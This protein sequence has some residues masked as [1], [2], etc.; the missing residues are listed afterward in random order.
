MFQNAEVAAE[1]GAAVARRHQLVAGRN[2]QL[3]REVRKALEVGR[4]AMD[5]SC[6]ESSISGVLSMA[7]REA[8]SVDEVKTVEKHEDE[9]DETTAAPEQEEEQLFVDVLCNHVQK[10]QNEQTTYGI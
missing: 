3:W 2:A 8:R 5:L 6:G 9:R 1:A 10:L 7:V 4:E